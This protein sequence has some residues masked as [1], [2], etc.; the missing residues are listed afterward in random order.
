MLHIKREGRQTTPVFRLYRKLRHKLSFLGIEL[1]I[2]LSQDR[3]YF[4][5]AF[6][7]HPNK[8]TLNDQIIMFEPGLKKFQL[9]IR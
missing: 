6:C 7:I 5:S 9:K 8:C 3:T 1:T 4:Y 2:S